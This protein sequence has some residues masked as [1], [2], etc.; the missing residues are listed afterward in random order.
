MGQ[1]H[2]KKIHENFQ[3]PGAPEALERCR[4]QWMRVR[5]ELSE[6]KRTGFQQGLADLTSEAVKLSM[7]V[8]RFENG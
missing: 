7:Q 8:K 6:L 3:P 4:R 1:T 5:L 2:L